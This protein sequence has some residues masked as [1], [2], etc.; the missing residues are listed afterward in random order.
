MPDVTP[1]GSAPIPAKPFFNP[2]T[3]Q[4]ALGPLPQAKR[5]ESDVIQ[6]RLQEGEELDIVAAGIPGAAN[7]P[8]TGVET[9]VEGK[10]LIH[11]A[12]HAKE[13]VASEVEGGSLGGHVVSKGGPSAK[14]VNDLFRHTGN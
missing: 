13:S 12:K 3:A 8:K 5:P 6:E 1:A 9:E 7:L 11:G 4:E 10:A 14:K 2:R